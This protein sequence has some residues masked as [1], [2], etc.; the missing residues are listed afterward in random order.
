[1]AL[2]PRSDRTLLVALASTATGMFLGTRARGWLE[3]APARRPPSAA[4]AAGSV[5]A[6]AA[7]LA[8]GRFARA[9]W[10]WSQQRSFG[11]PG[12]AMRIALLTNLPGSPALCSVL[13]RAARQLSAARPDMVVLGGSLMAK[14]EAT[15]RALHALSPLAR[16]GAPLGVFAVMDDLVALPGGSSVPRAGAII[17]RLG[18]LGV[19]VVDSARCDLAPGIS[20]RGLI[21]VSRPSRR[22][23]AM[24]TS[25]PT[26][27]VID[28]EPS[29]AS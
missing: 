3:R 9:R 13:R 22:K 14:L 27:T 20:L 21:E 18:M 19:E 29:E 4:A 15:P 16:L 23:V 17:A 11:W 24:L 7:L 8:C 2:A 10:L 25:R 28:L 12:P 6:L 26:L 1:M 5:A